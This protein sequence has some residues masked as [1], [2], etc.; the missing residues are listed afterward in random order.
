MTASLEL[1]ASF[2][3]V[4]V[5]FLEDWRRPTESTDLVIVL[6]HRQPRQQLSPGS[7]ETTRY[8]LGFSL[9]ELSF[10]L[11]VRRMAPRVDWVPR[12]QNEEADA[13]TNGDMR[14]F[15]EGL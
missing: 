7:A 8:P 15:S 5:L 10:Q 6:C 12:L 9:I 3:G 14:H 4:M 1:L 13:L 11:A 2:V